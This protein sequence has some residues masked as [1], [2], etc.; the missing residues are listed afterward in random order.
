MRIVLTRNGAKII[1]ELE[2]EDVPKRRNR[3]IDSINI[4]SSIIE[5]S[6]PFQN[7]NKNHS[8][9]TEISLKERK[10]V[11]YI[12]ANITEPSLYGKF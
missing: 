7:L 9:Y 4:S 2:F 8:N 1:K 11:R 12:L 6:N 3:T 5:E 10:L